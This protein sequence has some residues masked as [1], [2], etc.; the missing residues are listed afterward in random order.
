MT[1]SMLH[2]CPSLTK[3]LIAIS[4]LFIA[5]IRAISQDAG[6]VSDL[7]DLVTRG[8]EQLLTHSLTSL[9][10]K[11]ALAGGGGCVVEAVSPLRR[12]YGP[13]V[14]YLSTAAQRMSYGRVPWPAR[15]P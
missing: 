8:R 15:G 12:P 10:L 13:N 11:S 1:T 4:S 9:A 2:L 7:S 3:H 14:C 5:C 6:Q